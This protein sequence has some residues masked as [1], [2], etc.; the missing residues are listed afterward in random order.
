[1][2]VSRRR[3]GYTS[4]KKDDDL[5]NRLMELSKEHPRFGAR[6]LQAMLRREGRAVNLKRVRRLCRKHGFPK[7]KRVHVRMRDGSSF[8]DHWESK[9]SRYVVFRESGRVQ[10]KLIESITINRGP[11][12][13]Q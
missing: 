8:V 10:T 2:G 11:R 13:E 3:L 1:M 12:E 4:K 9:K 6:R 7:G 5:V